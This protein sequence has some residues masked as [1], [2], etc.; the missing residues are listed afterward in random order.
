MRTTTPFSGLSR[1]TLEQTI[2]LLQEQI[3]SEKRIVEDTRTELQKAARELHAVTAD[4][5]N[6]VQQMDALRKDLFGPKTERA[7]QPA[8]A[9]QT[10]FLGID[11][12]ILPEPEVETAASASAADTP[13]KETIIYTRAK[14]GGRNPIPRELLR[15]EIIL[16]ASD[17]DR[18]GPNGEALI[19]IGYETNEVLNLS[20]ERLELL[21]IKREKMGLPG[22][23]EYVSVVPQPER[24]IPKAK[25]TDA[26]MLT[27][28]LRKFE[29]GLPLYRQLALYNSWGAQL[30]SNY[31]GECV[32]HI[33]TAFEPI[34]AA[35]RRHVLSARWV[36]ADETP[37]RQLH[38]AH[39]PPGTPAV[40]TSYLWV[41]VGNNQVSFHYGTTRSSHEVRD[42]LGI[43]Y[44]PQASSTK[45]NPADFDPTTWEQGSDIGFLVCD[46]CPSYNVVFH[47]EQI[48]RIACWVHARRGFKR[49]EDSDRNAKYIVDLINAIF[50]AN[51]K[52]R[53]AAEKLPDHS[54]EQRWEVIAAQRQQ[55]LPPLIASL[56]DE[57][58]HLK[59]LYA[60]ETNVGRAITY[61]R[62]RWDDLQVFLAH[63]F[64]PMENNVAERAIRPIA[65][66]RKAWLFVGSEDGGA[67]A[68]TMFSIVESC[69]LQ[70]IDPRTYCEHVIPELIRARHDQQFDYGTLTP[71][72][73]QSILTK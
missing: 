45:R 67:W 54:D 48:R 42:V 58:T 55:C 63:G 68:A 41:W 32:R 36:H 73:L 69:R 24:L 37:I 4:R 29:Q 9:A 18:I 8:D 53:K 14:R 5:N 16:K 50:S 46:G 2:V 11:A 65:V 60:P 52:I 51:R 72:A 57:L 20:Q 66:G 10:T 3:V 31:L 71:A 7:R 34:A 6:L 35:I 17:E 40:G 25:V 22:T 56:D 15:R 38:P 23:H 43:P 62:N 33:A 1:Q 28:V 39:H 13:E 47:A 26:F 30:S 49:F 70:K 21:I 12:K 44:D 27:V 61:I 64:L 59:P 19:C